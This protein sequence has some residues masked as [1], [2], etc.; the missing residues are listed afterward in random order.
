M[1]VRRDLLFAGLF[2]IPLG[3]ITLLV[4]AGTI[5]ADALLD[6]PRLWPLMLVG[7]GL[8]LLLGRSRAASLG[9]AV[10]ALVLGVLVGSAIASGNVWIGN[11]AE[12]GPVSGST[13][14]QHIEQERHVRR[15]GR[16]SISRS[17]AARS[18]SRR[19]P[20]NDWA[21][22]GRLPGTRARLVSDAATASTSA[23]PTGERHPPPRLDDQGAGRPARVRAASSRTPRPARSCSTAPR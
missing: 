6:A 22:S 19:R 17:V 2:F 20:G 18:P 3:A 9:T 7:L 15:P 8:A 13:P 23:S 14:T 5:D 10:V 16:A 4:R 11:V 21:L 1:H 12:C